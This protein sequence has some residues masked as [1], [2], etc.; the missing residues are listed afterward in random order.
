ML[1]GGDSTRNSQRSSTAGRPSPPL[2]DPLTA[3]QEWRNNEESEQQGRGTLRRRR[4][5]VTFDIGEDVP[6]DGR[7]PVQKSLRANLEQMHQGQ[8]QGG[9]GA[10]PHA[11]LTSEATH[12]QPQQ[13]AQVHNHHVQAHAYAQMPMPS[14]QATA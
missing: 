8:G 1:T 4:P 14:R 5:G 10:P 2:R 9:A 7:Q 3:A 12:V 11:Q 13:H 6:E